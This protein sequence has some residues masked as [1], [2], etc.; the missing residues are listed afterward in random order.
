MHQLTSYHSSMCESLNPWPWR[1]LSAGD[2]RLPSLEPRERKA[3]PP[4]P[5]ESL[6]DVWLASRGGDDARLMA[7]AQRP[8]N[9]ANAQLAHSILRR[10]GGEFV[11]RAFSTI[12]TYPETLP[13]Q[14]HLVLPPHPLH[15]PD[16]SKY[17][18]ESFPGLPRVF[19]SELSPSFHS[20][21]FF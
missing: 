5:V 9:F 21:L 7:G 4:E 8:I 10:C 1:V 13:V 17:R 20:L 12:L 11:S 16:G 3:A 14:A 15:A 6:Y 18:Q 19:T 2:F